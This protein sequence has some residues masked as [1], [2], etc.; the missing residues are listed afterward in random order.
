[1][2]A[3]RPVKRVL[4]VAFGTVALAFVLYAAYDMWVRWD[5][6]RVRL[7]YG[8]LSAATACAGLAMLVQLYAFRVLVEKIGETQVPGVR[9][10]R[11]YIDSQ[12]ARYTPG[13]VGLAVVRIAGAEAVG[14]SRRLM[15]SAL[16]FE[17][18]SW[19]ATGVLVGGAVLF[20]LSG[21]LGVSEQVAQGASLLALGSLFVLGL[22]VSLDRTRYPGRLQVLWSEG[23]GPLVPWLVPVLH[24]LH[25]LIWV[26]CG[27]LVSLAVGASFQV[28]FMA[29]GLLCVAIVA[30]FLAFLAPAGA[31]VREAILAA[32]LTPL[33]GPTTSVA[34]G[35]LARAASL[36][37]DV[38]LFVWFRA[39][40][41]FR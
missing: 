8:F 41:R 33:L 5:G 23:D 29:G 31:G 6:A 37:S 22:L 30:G 40:K 19:C 2:E 11:L 34:V 16:F 12:M 7:H 36:L 10:A 32:G 24:T 39:N 27:A 9:F 1:M 26:V 20:S 13:K 17:V 3:A 4:R 25:F 18:I 28:A 14:V 15:G 38:L 35:L 21:V